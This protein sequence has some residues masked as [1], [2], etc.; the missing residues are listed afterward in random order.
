VDGGG[1]S[2]QLR[3]AVAPEGSHWIR[4]KDGDPA[5]L[6]LYRRHY[7]RHVYRDGR[8]PKLFAGPG[9][10]LVLITA[11]LRALFVWRKFK[12]DSGQVGINCAIFR[13]EGPVL[14]SLLI[15]EAEGLA[16]ARWPN[17]TRLYTYVNAG[18][19]RAKR[20]PGRCFIRAGWKL[21]GVTKRNRL[22]I[23]EK[24]RAPSSAPNTTDS[25]CPRPLPAV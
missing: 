23:F 11:D 22:L 19:V 17:E 13:N 16:W 18:K 21:C 8:K 5:G 1:V 7:S 3:M 10:K 15:L 12:D 4:S 24:E 20:D 2:L 14:S 6:A 25:S 9:F